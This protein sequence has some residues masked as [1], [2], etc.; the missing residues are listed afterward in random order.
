MSKGITLKHIAEQI[1]KS[2]ANSNVV[3]KAVSNT[4]PQVFFVKYNELVK[5][6]EY[7][8]GVENVPQINSACKKYFDDLKKVFPASPDSHRASRLFFVEHLRVTNNIFSIR[9][10][11]PSSGTDAYKWMF[12]KLA[13]L[14][15]RLYKDVIKYTKKEFLQKDFLHISHEGGSEIAYNK[16]FMVLEALNEFFNVRPQFG[17]IHGEIILEVK[18]VL[19]KKFN[20]VESK[21]SVVTMLSG[22]LNTKKAPIE[23][24]LGQ[25]IM[26]EALKTIDLRD[27][28]TSEIKTRIPRDLLGAVAKSQKDTVAKF[29]KH[30]FYSN[31]SRV[32][33]YKLK[34]KSATKEQI[35][36]YKATLKKNEQRFAK[37]ANELSLH[38]IFRV[39]QIQLP[40]MVE[41]QMGH[42]PRRAIKDPTKPLNYQ[43]GTFAGSVRP[44]SVDNNMKPDIITIKYTY[45]T[46]PYK[47]YEHEN[48][49]RSPRVREG[50][51][52][53]ANF[54]PFQR[55]DP[56]YIIERSIR[57]IAKQ[58][59][60]TKFQLERVEVEL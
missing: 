18:N 12:R 42:L 55:R 19:K 50:E 51:I 29:S 30:K 41:Q 16:G 48:I 38:S 43:S 34:H 5:Q 2:I 44:V 52:N 31:T 27:F 57:Q 1:I 14:K 15:T 3:R 56:R 26:D 11:P 23:A 49:A 45:D 40:Y 37:E 8:L 58:M 4:K 24:R 36:E 13:P 54:L 17:T 46:H 39:L 10:I 33:S 47:V 35:N 60:K 32:D 25:E 22:E 20:L 28:A 6:V 59:I 7:S 9:I 21:S 53:R